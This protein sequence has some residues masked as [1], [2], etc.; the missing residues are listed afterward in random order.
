MAGPTH[1]RD[2]QNHQSR[3]H[4]IQEVAWFLT[5]SLTNGKA[6][7]S[8]F[9]ILSKIA[10]TLSWNLSRACTSNINARASDV[11]FC[12]L[13]SAVEAAEKV[14][15]SGPWGVMHMCKLAPG[16]LSE[17]TTL[18]HGA[19]LSLKCSLNS[20]VQFWLNKILVHLLWGVLHRWDFQEGWGHP[21]TQIRQS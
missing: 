3:S 6:V 5:I 21:R 11:S 14:V 9:K 20:N 8:F 17:L 7:I 16:T 10:Q 1:L 18:G 2:N 13:R 4:F 15:S 19:T 12:G